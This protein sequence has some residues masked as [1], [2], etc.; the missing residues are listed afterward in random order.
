MLQLGKK[1]IYSDWNF[2]EIDPE[3]EENQI[4]SSRGRVGEERRVGR[5]SL[6]L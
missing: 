4:F 1:E 3:S 2:A 5:G 6:K